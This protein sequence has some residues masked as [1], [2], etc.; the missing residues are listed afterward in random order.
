MKLKFFFLAVLYNSLLN[1]QVGIGTTTPNGALDITSTTNG[2][3]PPR[4]ALTAL[5]VASPIV[6]PAGGAVA[7][8]TIVWNTATANTGVAAPPNS[9]APGLY[10][11][12]G[13]K[14]IAFTGTTG[15]LD[16]SLNGNVGTNPTNDFAGTT[17][18]NDFVLR[19]NNS[20]VGRFYNNTST[21][22]ASVAFAGGVALNSNMVVSGSNAGNG[23]T[24]ASG[25]NFLGN[26]SGRGATSASSSN[27]FG[28]RTGMDATGA[29][30]SNFFGNEAGRQATNA[31][32]SNFIGYQAGMDAS[33]SN[34]SNFFGN[35]AGLGASNAPYSN[36]LGNRA[37]YAAT[38]AAS[39]NFLGWNAGGSATFANGSNFL[40]QDS[41][42]GATNAGSSN[43]LGGYSG[44]NAT[45]ASNSN[46]FGLNAGINSIDASYSNFFGQYA[47]GNA[48]NATYS[49]FIGFRAGNQAALASYSNVF[50]YL[51]GHSYAGNNIGS[52]NII[53][54]T[55]ITLPNAAANSM[56]IGGVLF[57]TGLN[58]NIVANPLIVPVS[59]S[60]IGIGVVIPNSKLQ[61][62]GPIS[63]AVNN[64][65]STDPATLTITDAM[66]VV[67][68]DANCTITLPNPTI[69]AGRQLTFLR[70][71][72]PAAPILTSTTNII[73]SIGSTTTNIAGTS[74][75][76]CIIVSDGTNWNIVN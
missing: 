13:S 49:N 54:G 10:Y 60:N 12:N 71:N 28:F 76:T 50:G 21:S 6:N 3:L 55:N 64:Y 16:W 53:I 63:T 7:Q 27:F 35:I 14:W 62:A 32:Y 29:F 34:N 2:F 37:G 31:T 17:D 9:I 59:N 52:N 5:N 75:N 36:F 72:N 69:C 8:G 24:G 57:G 1:A 38:N 70:H 19:A 74:G 40:G 51:A 68:F 65:K 46:F 22:A 44:Q 66:S 43:F 20:I 48:T 33:A 39:S 15:G 45:N 25:S 4:V 73:D 56:N 42:S 41:G 67:V 26:S 58:S 61:V 47:G 18:A 30:R 11:W 23:A